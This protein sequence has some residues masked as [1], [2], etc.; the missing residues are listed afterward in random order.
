MNLPAPTPEPLPP[1]TLPAALDG[2]DGANRAHD[3]Y[4]QIAADTD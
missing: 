4:R 2:W 1:F 3:S